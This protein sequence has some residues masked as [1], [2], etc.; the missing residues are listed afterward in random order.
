[1]S[2]QPQKFPRSPGCFTDWRELKWGEITGLDSGIA[3]ASKFLGCDI[4][5]L[6]EWFLTLR[7]L[8]VSALSKVSSGRRE[9]QLL[10]TEEESATIFLRVENHSPKDTASCTIRLRVRRSDLHKWHNVHIKYRYYRSVGWTV[11]AGGQRERLF[12]NH[13]LSRMSGRNTGQKLQ[14]C[15]NVVIYCNKLADDFGIN[16]SNLTFL[17]KL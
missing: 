17:T 3:K 8:V 10:T 12:H 2:L 13:Q 11:A 5:T 9:H 14:N 4:V 1:M 6:S 15:P 7:R 16:A